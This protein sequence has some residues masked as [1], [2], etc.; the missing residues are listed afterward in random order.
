VI[1]SPLV[2]V[3][4]PFGVFFLPPPQVALGSER[5][6]QPLYGFSSVLSQ[7]RTFEVKMSERRQ[8]GASSVNKNKNW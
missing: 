4:L 3:F 6:V 1:S 8:R 7:S 5:E 2:W